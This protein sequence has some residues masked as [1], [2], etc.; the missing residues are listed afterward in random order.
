M[1]ACSST[2]RSGT[3]PPN[4]RF[5]DQYTLEQRADLFWQAIQLTNKNENIM[6]DDA[7]LSALF[8]TR[9]FQRGEAVDIFGHAQVTGWG[10]KPQGLIDAQAEFVSW[11]CIRYITKSNSNFQSENSK[12]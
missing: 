9:K 5:A 11:D 10:R 4:A 7:S 6:W 2:S 1:G 3:T 8:C 12:F